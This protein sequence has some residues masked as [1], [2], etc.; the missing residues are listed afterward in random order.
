MN[1]GVV[2][3]YFPIFGTLFIPIDTPHRTGQAAFPHPAPRS[4]IQQASALRKGFRSLQV[5]QVS[6]PNIL[7]TPFE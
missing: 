2:H 5:G 1:P 7:S 4:A 3:F 6:T